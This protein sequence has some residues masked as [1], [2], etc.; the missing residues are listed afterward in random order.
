MLNSVFG[1]IC[2]YKNKNKVTFKKVNCGYCGILED[3]NNFESFKID[4]C[5]TNKL[6]R[7]NLDLNE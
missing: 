7:S 5:L 1:A 6:T 3:T 2:D 4:F